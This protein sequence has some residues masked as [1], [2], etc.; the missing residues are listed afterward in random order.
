[1]CRYQYIYELTITSQ[2]FCVNYKQTVLVFSIV[3]TNLSSF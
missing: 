1:M 2:F 3:Q